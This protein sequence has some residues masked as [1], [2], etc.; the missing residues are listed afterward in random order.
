MCT[1]NLN[2]NLSGFQM[3]PEKNFVLSKLVYSLS[4]EKTIINDGPPYANGEIHLGHALNKI[5]KDI[6]SRWNENQFI[7]GFDCHG[8]P[9]ELEVEKK[10]SGSKKDKTKFMS[11]CRE[12]ADIQIQK[13]IGGFQKLGINVD[14]TNS[15]KTMN[16]ETEAN[17]LKILRDLYEKGFVVPG[18]KPTHWCPQCGSSL[19]DNEIEYNDVPA[20]EVYFLVPVQSMEN[21][22]LCVM[23]TTPWT[24]PSNQGMC[25][26]KKDIE[27]G[28]F[29][30]EK[31]GKN[32]ILSKKLG[33]KNFL[34]WEYV[35]NI[36]FGEHVK[37]R[38]TSVPHPL[39][40]LCKGS[41]QPS[42]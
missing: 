2:M 19:S 16:F 15:Y 17:E 30:S 37:L 23:T 14:W 9:I 34:G 11:K 27:Y 5:I 12:Y 25:F 6:I 41:W 1:E 31:L 20:K 35:K 40:P 24:I 36:T 22:Y 18:L 26:N 33:M 32:I 4:S 10:S 39:A 3:R 29:S 28:L 13:Q 8:L 38:G 21:T 7:P 42:G